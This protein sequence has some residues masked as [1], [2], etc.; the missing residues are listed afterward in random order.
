ML[1]IIERILAA[2]I[3][4]ALLVVIMFIFFPQ[5]QRNVA[6]A[7]N[8]APSTPRPVPSPEKVVPLP[9]QTETASKD[10]S[11]KEDAKPFAKVVDRIGPADNQN[12]I[13]QYTRRKTPQQSVRR[14][15]PKDQ[16]RN[17]ST[18]YVKTAGY[19]YAESP[20]HSDPSDCSGEDCYCGCDGPYW[21]RSSFSCWDW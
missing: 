3:I 8:A 15:S 19:R 20:V 12:P 2:M 1:E 21:A 18:P 5:A 10:T 17:V 13:Y 16:S 7:P 4:L 9:E 11:G 6:E 14:S